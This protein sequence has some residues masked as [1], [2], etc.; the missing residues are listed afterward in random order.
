[1]E[2][3][4]MH[5]AGNDYV[6]MNASNLSEDWS[7][8]AVNVSDRHKGIG[9]DG[10]ILA[11]PSEI[12]D[13][14]MRMFNSDG[15]EGEMCGNGIR[16]LVGF[17]IDQNL[18][19]SK[20]KTVLVET[21]AGVLSVTP[22]RTN[23]VMTG[24]TVSM[25]LP[26]LEPSQIP[27]EID[28]SS[29]PVL[30]HTLNIG[31]EQMKLSFIS[32]GN[33]HAISFIDEDIDKYPLTEIGPLVEN[34]EIFPNKINFEIVN[35]IDRSHLKVRVWERGSGITLACGTGACAVAVAA[36]L[37]GIIDDSCTIS[38][39]GGDLEISWIDNN[40]VLMTGP[41]EKVFSGNWKQ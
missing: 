19:P 23:N 26:I 16:C 29:F 36:K 34:H 20:Q 13:I 32:M 24:A 30:D 18:I 25:G 2:F 21:G 7:Q 39:P 17:A 15:S 37:K 27:V 40:E 35:I 6:Y 31:Y 14:K 8:I 9:S 3:T 22:I 33:P 4:K 12:A 38:L 10:L 1:M 11:M 5:G 41:I 28:S